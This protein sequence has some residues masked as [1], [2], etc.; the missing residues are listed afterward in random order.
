MIQNYQKNDLWDVDR[1][2]C[3]KQELKQ[4]KNRL[5]DFSDTI[6]AVSRRMLDYDRQAGA[7]LFKQDM[8]ARRKVR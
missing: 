1:E 4:Y 8:I 6:I 5:F 3:I 7:T 2:S